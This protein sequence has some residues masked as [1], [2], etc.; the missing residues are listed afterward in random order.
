MRIAIDRDRCIGSAQCV[1]AAPGIFTQDDEAIGEVLP[2]RE[3]D[4]DDPA[5][6]EG[7]EAC[8]VG[9]VAIAED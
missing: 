9:A 8:P 3:H 4:A 1:L 7:I 5:A 6:V 2:G